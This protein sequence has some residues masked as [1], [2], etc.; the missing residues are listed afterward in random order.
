VQCAGVR[1]GGGGGHHP[2]PHPQPV[3]ADLLARQ[4][5]QGGQEDHRPRAAQGKHPISEADIKCRLFTY[6]LSHIF[7]KHWIDTAIFHYNLGF[8]WRSFIVPD[9]LRRLF[10]CTVRCRTFSDFFYNF[11]LMWRSFIKPGTW[12]VTASFYVQ[13]VSYFQKIL[14]I[15]FHCQSFVKND[16]FHA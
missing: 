2:L 16:Y 5:G 12:Y 1:G 8:I 7:R 4:H 15:R 13:V 9:T 10:T 6:K 3:Q 14:R 11:G